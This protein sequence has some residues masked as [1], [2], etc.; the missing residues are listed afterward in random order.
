MRGHELS[1]ATMCACV[2][3][4]ESVGGGGWGQEGQHTRQGRSRAIRHAVNNSS[5]LRKERR[6]QE[7]DPTL[8]DW[9]RPSSLAFMCEFMWVF[10]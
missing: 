7:G 3:Q 9:T 2:Q 10:M 6:D 5:K 8:G 4:G 1:G